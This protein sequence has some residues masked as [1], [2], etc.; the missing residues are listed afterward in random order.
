[1]LLTISCEVSA[2]FQNVVK[3]CHTIC[4]L[5]AEECIEESGMKLAVLTCLAR[6]LEIKCDGLEGE[7]GTG[8]LEKDQQIL[9]AAKQSDGET[10]LL[11]F[12][13]ASAI[14]SGGLE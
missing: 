9:E 7:E 4:L 10:S 2:S 12:P 14:A 5:G 13:L 8:P 6:M 11:K 3:P 1:M